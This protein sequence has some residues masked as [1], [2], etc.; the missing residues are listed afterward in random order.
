MYDYEILKINEL[1]EYFWI[2]IEWYIQQIFHIFNDKYRLGTNIL[3]L[4]NEMILSSI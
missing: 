4:I 1:I 3:D 2:Q